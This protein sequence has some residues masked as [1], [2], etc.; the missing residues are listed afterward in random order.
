MESW[1]ERRTFHHARFEDLDELRR[2]K[3]TQG[4]TVSV[5]IPTLNEAA[6]VGPIIDAV[7]RAL[8]EDVPLVDELAIV[9]SASDDDTAGVAEAAGAVVFQDRDLVPDLPHLGGKGDAMWKSLFALRGDLV[10]WIDADVE[11]FHPRFVYGLLGPLLLDPG[12]EYVKGFYERPLRIGGETDP[13]GGGR[14]TELMARPLINAFW[15]DLAG[16]IQPLSGEYGGRRQLLER[17]PFFTGY[18]VELAML[19]D[20]LDASGLDAI[21]QVDLHRR[22]HRNRN[23]GDLS[24]M[25]YAILQGAAARLRGSGALA[26]DAFVG[27]DLSLFA[28]ED[29]SYRI[30]PMAVPIHE[31]PPAAS[32][33]GYQAR[34]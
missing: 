29:G 21:A 12:V 23:I 3:E 7:R 8:V 30:R 5:C 19:I 28:K 10:L 32:V 15:P 25:A 34:G 20:I 26:E 24:R 27:G 31:R 1:F 9:D 33:S 17:I 18:A 2:A 4:L 13:F 16:I 11:D 6:T 14:V 22:T